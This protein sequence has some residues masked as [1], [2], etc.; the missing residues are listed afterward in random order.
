MQKST[1]YKFG[2]TQDQFVQLYSETR[3]FNRICTFGSV[4][5]AQMD[6]VSVLCF[7]GMGQPFD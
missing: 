3:S 2:F 6:V 4:V 7:T 5:S 1:K